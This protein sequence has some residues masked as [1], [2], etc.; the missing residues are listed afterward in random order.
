MCV[1]EC[2]TKL[3]FCPDGTTQDTAAGEFELNESK[4]R[5][6][7]SERER[8]L[9]FSHVKFESV[10][11]A[12]FFGFSFFCFLLLLHLCSSLF[13]IISDRFGFSCIAFCLLDFLHRL[14]LESFC[15]F[16]VFAS[17]LLCFFVLVYLHFASGTVCL[18]GPNGNVE[19]VL[20]SDCPA[21]S[22]APSSGSSPPTSSPTGTSA[23]GT[24]P[25]GFQGVMCKQECG[26]VLLFCPQGIEQSTPAGTFEFEVKH[27]KGKAKQINPKWH[28]CLLL[29]CFHCLLLLLLL[30]IFVAFLVPVDFR[31]G[32]CLSSLSFSACFRSL[33]L[34]LVA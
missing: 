28:T 9:F 22:T 33:L 19:Q 27:R 30:S 13:C 32:D 11:E 1:T 17:V 3:L 23:P 20:P 2:G 10:N 34:V 18:T 16:I 4:G 31:H 7:G 29:F 26:T 14:F 8:A 24:C 21:P 6:E 15:A 25:P 5:K 12:E